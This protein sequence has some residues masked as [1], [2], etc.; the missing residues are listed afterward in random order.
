M[1]YPTHCRMCASMKKKVD[2]WSRDSKWSKVRFYICNVD[3]VPSKKINDL[4]FFFEEN[5]QF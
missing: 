5:D 4:K 3:D 1:L 2:K